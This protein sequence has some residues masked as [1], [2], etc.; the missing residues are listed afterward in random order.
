MCM[1]CPSCSHVRLPA[2]TRR[3]S[4]AYACVPVH[5]H[6]YS[7]WFIIHIFLFKEGGWVAY[8]PSPH[9]VNNRKWIITLGLGS[10]FGGLWFSYF[11]K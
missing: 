3:A 9:A 2:C 7:L 8:A 4:C 1:L 11:N 5:L 6:L 10:S